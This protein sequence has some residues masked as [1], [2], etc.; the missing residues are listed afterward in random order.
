M[1][2][3]F[4]HSLPQRESG[5]KGRVLSIYNSFLFQPLKN[6]KEGRKQSRPPA[7]PP[8]TR[9]IPLLFWGREYKKQLINIKTEKI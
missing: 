2:N 3:N 7:F 6:K 5:E 4:E 8:K 1:K 9:K